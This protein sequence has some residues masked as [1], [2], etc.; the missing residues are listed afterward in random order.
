MIGQ[1]VLIV[2]TLDTPWFSHYSSIN[3]SLF[4][5]PFHSIAFIVL[6]FQS[7]PYN[8]QSMALSTALFKSCIQSSWALNY[9]S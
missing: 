3:H 1:A 8:H 2:Q 4:K 5:L 7:I 9:T 6:Q